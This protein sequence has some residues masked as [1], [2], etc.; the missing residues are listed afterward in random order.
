M[1][2]GLIKGKRYWE[3]VFRGTRLSL[4][5]GFIFRKA[6]CRSVWAKASKLSLMLH[7]SNESG[8]FHRYHYMKVL[9]ISQSRN[10]FIH[11]YRPSFQLSTPSRPLAS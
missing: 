5:T 7:K 4:F 10:C 8:D 2:N 9:F 11:L 3:T 1:V 6:R